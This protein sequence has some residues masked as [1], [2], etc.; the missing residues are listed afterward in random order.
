MRKTHDSF[1]MVTPK[2]TMLLAALGLLSM[3]GCNPEQSKGT[4]L[5]LELQNSENIHQYWVFNP[6]N[7]TIEKC[8]ATAKQA[9]AEIIAKNAIPKDSIVTS[10]RCSFNPPERVR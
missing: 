7:R 3:L 8:N 2:I 5:I 9:I 1:S 4:V 10:W 6:Y